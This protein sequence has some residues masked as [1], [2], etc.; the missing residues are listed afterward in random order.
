MDAKLLA[1]RIVLLFLDFYKALPF[2]LFVQTQRPS[3]DNIILFAI[4]SNLVGTKNA[5]GSSRIPSCE[6]DFGSDGLHEW[7]RQSDASG[8]GS[9]APGEHMFR[10][11]V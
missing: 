10:A 11:C 8:H 5:K 7:T 3:S 4:F 2:C 9:N 6:C 1:L